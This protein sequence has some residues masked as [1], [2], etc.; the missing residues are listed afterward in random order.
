MP[1][2]KVAAASMIL[3]S[4]DDSSA[5]ASAFFAASA[6]KAA[7]DAIAQAPAH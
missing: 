4:R 1:S 5:S 2:G 7:R 3:G 6:F